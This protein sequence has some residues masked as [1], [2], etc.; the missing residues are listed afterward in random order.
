[1]CINTDGNFTCECSNGYQLDIDG[2]SCNG[3]YTL[4]FMYK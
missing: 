3:M 2:T 4:R 1:M